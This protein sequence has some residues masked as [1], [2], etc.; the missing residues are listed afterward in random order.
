MEWT[1]IEVKILKCYDRSILDW[2]RVVI[3]SIR[4]RAPLITGTIDCLVDEAYREPSE[5][6]DEVACRN[7]QACI[8]SVVAMWS[9]TTIECTSCVLQLYVYVACPT[10]VSYGFYLDIFQM[11]ESAFNKVYT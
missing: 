5:A 9:T 8:T 6:I 3:E 11:V 1:G 7:P 4:N 10:Q 2:P